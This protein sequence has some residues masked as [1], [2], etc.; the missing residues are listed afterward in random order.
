MTARNA[1]CTV[2]TIGQSLCLAGVLGAV[3]VATL[4]L[5]GG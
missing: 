3:V 1:I 2:A 5:I 4:Q